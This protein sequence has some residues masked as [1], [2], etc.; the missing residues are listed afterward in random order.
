MHVLIR[1]ATVDDVDTLI[2]IR[3]SVVQNHLSVEQMADDA[4]VRFKKRRAR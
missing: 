4:D 1:A 3:T 2:T